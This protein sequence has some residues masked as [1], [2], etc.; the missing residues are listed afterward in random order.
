MGKIATTYRQV[1]FWAKFGGVANQAR[2]LIY[3]VMHDCCL[4][5]EWSEK[6]LQLDPKR[7]CPKIRKRNLNTT[8]DEAWVCWMCKRKCQRCGATIVRPQ[9]EQHK[10]MCAGCAI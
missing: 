1:L 9:A 8:L 3:H 7:L 5:G 2:L 4:C 6:L 10:G